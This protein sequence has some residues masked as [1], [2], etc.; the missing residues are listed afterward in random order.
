MEEKFSKGHRRDAAQVL[1]NGGIAGL[2]V[3]LGQFF[4]GAFWPWLAFSGALAAANADTWA[5]EL[6][7]LSKLPPR[8]IRTAKVVEP[9]DSGGVSW[10][11]L[12]AATGGSLL[13]AG[14][15]VLP[16]PGLSAE[17]GLV[18]RGLVILL[19]T[20]AGLGGSLVDSLLGATVQVIYTCPACGKETERHPLHRCGTKTVYKRGWLWMNNDA[21]NAF[22]TSSGVIIVLVGG[23]LL[24]PLG[25]KGSGGELMNTIPISSPAF[26][27]GQPIPPKFTC[28]GENL[29]PELQWGEIPAGIKSLVLVMDDPDAPM[30]TF[31]HWVIYNIPPTLTGLPE[32]VSTEPQVSGIGTQGVN[33]ARRTGYTGP[34]PPPGK[35]H[36]YFFTLYA[37]DIWTIFDPGFSKE[38]LLQQ[39][40]GHVLAQGQVMGTYQ[41]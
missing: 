16:W 27:Q 21:V 31:V 38:Q 1:A 13:I 11:G 33:S 4:P 9:G 26:A 35:P 34:C 14:L 36:R 22:C 41:R 20:L 32:G 7:V 30:G 12:L 39:I 10:L 40:E 28:E 19:I 37:L 3:L 5:T 8:S 15:A 29:S 25:S 17:S 2:C 24:P 23:M 18:T 6:G